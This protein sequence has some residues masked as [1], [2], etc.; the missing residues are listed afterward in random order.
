MTNYTFRANKETGEYL[1]LRGN[2]IVAPGNVARIMN[3]KFTNMFKSLNWNPH[4]VI[5]YKRPKNIPE[6][7]FNQWLDAF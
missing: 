5:M 6:D 3:S 4:S 1:I 7:E 2:K